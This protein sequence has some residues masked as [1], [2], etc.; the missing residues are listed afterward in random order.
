MSLVAGSLGP[1]FRVLG[2]EGAYEKAGLDPQEDQLGS[3]MVPSEEGYGV[4]PSD[5]WGRLVRGDGAGPVATE[6]G[7]YQRFYAGVAAA[8]RDG[9]A[10]PVDPDDAIETLEILEAAAASGAS[11]EVVPIA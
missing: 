5:R 3:G 8:I 10:P 4:E 7:A 9:S 6:R 1:R 11:G 2:L